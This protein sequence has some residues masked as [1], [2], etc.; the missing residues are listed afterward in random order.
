[1]GVECRRE[2]VAAPLT[3]AGRRGLDS[4]DADC[5][6]Q[7]GTIFRGVTSERTMLEGW[8]R[9]GDR[10]D[11]TLPGKYEL[12]ETTTGKRLGAFE[13]NPPPRTITPKELRDY[14]F[15]QDLEDDELAGAFQAGDGPPPGIVPA[16]KPASAPLWELRLRVAG[17]GP[18]DATL[19][20]ITETYRGTKPVLLDH[21]EDW[22]EFPC[23]EGGLSVSHDV[24][25]GSVHPTALG[26]KWMGEFPSKR[27]PQELRVI[28]PG[29]VVRRIVPVEAFFDLSVGGIY[30]VSVHR[31]RPNEEGHPQWFPSNTLIFEKNSGIE[32]DWM[33]IRGWKRKVYSLEP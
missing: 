7:A 6:N 23:F 26:R 27:R 15:V 25:G 1:M 16:P 30:R 24:R 18:M 10:Q 28:Q 9:L 29:A 22:P 21:S 19:V 31:S 11:L 4:V 20:E 17:L 12:V 14:L 2:G 33:A 8:R 5:L 13:V 3:R 32:A